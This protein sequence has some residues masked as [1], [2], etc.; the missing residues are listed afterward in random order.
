MRVGNAY[1]RCPGAGQIAV[2]QQC[3]IPGSGSA[4]TPTHL[5][6]SD[7]LDTVQDRSDYN[8]PAESEMQSVAQINKQMI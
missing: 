7:W 5:A 4:Q 8:E 2:P 3:L 6:Q 1:L